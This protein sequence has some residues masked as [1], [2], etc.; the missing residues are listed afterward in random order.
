[1]KNWT[2]FGPIGPSRWSQNSL[3]VQ[4]SHFFN[5]PYISRNV[6][7]E[8]PTLEESVGRRPQPFP[9][10]D[11]KPIGRPALLPSPSPPKPMVSAIQWTT[12]FW[13]NIT[14]PTEPTNSGHG[15]VADNNNNTIAVAATP[16]ANQWDNRNTWVGIER[17]QRRQYRRCPPRLPPKW[18]IQPLATSR[19]SQTDSTDNEPTAQ[20][21]TPYVQPRIRRRQPTQTECVFCKNNNE[22]PDVYK[23]H[24][25]KDPECRI[26]CPVLRAY[27]CPICHNGGGPY[28]HTVRYCPKN[29]AGIHLKLDKMTARSVLMSDMY[30]IQT[31][32]S[33]AA[34]D[35]KTRYY[36]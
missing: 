25:L 7:S 26:V 30:T 10:Y 24:I 17:V 14:P 34:E 32:Q 21:P 9:G 19:S 23:S 13:N 29:R 20:S 36:D 5:R 11:M 12:N 3:S 1:M 8:W 15:L 33:N 31:S 18:P 4:N 16:M 35:T 2:P 6:W 22:T 27:D 28:A